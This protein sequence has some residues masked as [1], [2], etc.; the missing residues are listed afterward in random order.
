MLMGWFDFFVCLFLCFK[1][2]CS[3]HYQL[4]IIGTKAKECTAEDRDGNL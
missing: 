1:L 2:C 4:L 3:L